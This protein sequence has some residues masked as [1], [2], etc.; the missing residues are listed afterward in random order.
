MTAKTVATVKETKETREDL[1]PETLLEMYEWMLLARR[2]DERAWLLRRQGK[3]TFHIS[4]MG[5][6]AIHIGTAYAIRR[7]YDILYPYYRDLGLCLAVG[8]TP[9]EFMLG[10]FGRK[11]LRAG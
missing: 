8:M 9:R 6:E 4:G 2:L 7:G 10:L 1:N 11:M 5:H 3:I